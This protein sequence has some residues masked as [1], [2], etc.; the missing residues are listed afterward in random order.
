MQNVAKISP[1]R[2]RHLCV[3]FVIITG[4]IDLL[5]RLR[6]CDFPPGPSM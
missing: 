6:W 4:G 5:G 2:H 3:T 1:S